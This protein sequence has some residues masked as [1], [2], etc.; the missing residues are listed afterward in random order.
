MFLCGCKSNNTDFPQTDFPIG[1]Q[2]NQNIEIDGVVRSFHLYLPENPKNA[3]IVFLLHGNR[4][5]ADQLLG[6]TGLVAPNKIWMNIA[7]RENLILVVPDGALGPEGHQGWNDCRTDALN[8]PKTDDVQFV[9]SLID[10]ITT[11]YKQADSKIFSVG[12]SNGGMMSMRL[13]DEIPN[14]LH[15]FAAIVA[16]RPIN[17]KCADADVPVSALIMNGTADPILP[18]TG[19]HIRPRRGELYSTIDTV[20]YWVN[21]NQ[22]NTTS[23]FIELDNSEADD[24]STVRIQSYD[25]GTNN[26]R[27]VHYE[28][29]DGGHTEPSIAEQYDPLYKIV[30]GEQNNDIESAEEIWKFFSSL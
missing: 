23:G 4:G 30:V 15:A 26:S 17:T 10:E 19:G 7:Q 27:V 12:V 13:A 21:R 6:L 9:N 3:Q 11:K 5:S 14:R 24:N 16:S 25:N 28:M 20:A 22:A 1:L 29:I 2:T 8:N 18:Y